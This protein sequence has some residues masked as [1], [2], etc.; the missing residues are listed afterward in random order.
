MLQFSNKTEHFEINLLG[1]N[2]EQIKQ[3]NS[4]KV[5][6]VV[7]NDQLTFTEFLNDRINAAKRAFF[8]F[9]EI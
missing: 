6:G 4:A 9:L 7:I 2:G 8:T 5:L 3:S 1:P